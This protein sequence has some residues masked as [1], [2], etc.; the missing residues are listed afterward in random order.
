MGAGYYDNLKVSTFALRDT[1]FLYSFPRNTKW[2]EVDQVSVELDFMQVQRNNR[3]RLTPTASLTAEVLING[4]VQAKET[5][6]TTTPF[7]NV[8]PSESL[9]LTLTAYEIAKH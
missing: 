4:V 9:Y 1:T 6:D 5:L 2:Q 7:R 3:V 8:W